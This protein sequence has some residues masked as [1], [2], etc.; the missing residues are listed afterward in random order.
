MSL[1]DFIKKLR[2]MLEN[3]NALALDGNCLYIFTREGELVS[4]DFWFV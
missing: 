2:F 1:N 4:F 3:P